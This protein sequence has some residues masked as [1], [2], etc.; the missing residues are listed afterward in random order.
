MWKGVG[1]QVPGGRSRV[2]AEREIAATKRVGRAARG[3]GGG[4]VWWRECTDMRSKRVRNNTM[5]RVCACV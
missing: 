4:V 2:R 3:G 1:N 5:V